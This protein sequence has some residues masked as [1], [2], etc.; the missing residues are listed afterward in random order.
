MPLFVILVTISRRV[1]SP[2]LWPSA[3]GS[4]RPAGSHRLGMPSASVP[5][6]NSSAPIF[7][8]FECRYFAMREKLTGNCPQK[9]FFVLRSK[10]IQADFRPFERFRCFVVRPS[11]ADN[12]APCGCNVA[13]VGRPARSLWLDLAGS[14]GLRQHKIFAVRIRSDFF[15]SPDLCRIL[16]NLF[17]MSA[18]P[19]ALCVIFLLSDSPLYCACI[20]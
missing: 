4:G 16:Y 3:S 13:A 10:A 7:L 20:T 6:L 11:S 2:D 14:A 17:A 19:S 18:G 5:D 9:N 15:L 12:G 1:F 8:F